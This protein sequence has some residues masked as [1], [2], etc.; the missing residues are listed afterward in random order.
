VKNIDAKTVMEAVQQLHDI[1]STKGKTC[2]CA[3]IKVFN[4]IPLGRKGKPSVKFAV[5]TTDFKDRDADH[6]SDAE[7][8]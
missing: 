2:R 5:A 4:T 1:I 6:S 7:N 3:S 8:C